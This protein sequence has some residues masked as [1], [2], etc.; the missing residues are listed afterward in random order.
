MG[1]AKKR[2]SEHMTAHKPWHKGINDMKLC[3]A[4][5]PDNKWD[6]DKACNLTH[7]ILFYRD[8]L[9]GI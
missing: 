3:K 1:I 6:N 5:W 4:T 2:I 7:W 8:L 9:T